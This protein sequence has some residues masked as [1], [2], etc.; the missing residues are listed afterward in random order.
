MKKRKEKENR[1][2]WTREWLLERNILAELRLK[3][4][5]EFRKYLRMNTERF[6]VLT[7]VLLFKKTHYFT[8]FCLID[9]LTFRTVSVPLKIFQR[10]EIFENQFS[11][12]SCLRN[13]SERFSLIR[14]Y[15]PKG[16]E[17]FRKV[18][19]GFEIFLRNVSEIFLKEIFT[20]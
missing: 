7:L 2:I 13:I 16:F 19:K 10:Q 12:I 18:S 14:R 8:T 15:V 4:A 9:S 5:E 3:D 17:R 6:E 1:K 11:K 20:V